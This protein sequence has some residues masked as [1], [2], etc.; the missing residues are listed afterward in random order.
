M[1][2]WLV[3]RRSHDR[4]DRAVGA[5]GTGWT[6]GARADVSLSNPTRTGALA[7][8]LVAHPGLDRGPGRRGPGARSPPDR[9]VARR[10]PAAR[11]AR[12]GLRAKRWAPPALDS[13]Q[14]AALNAAVQD[15]PHAAGLELANWNWKVV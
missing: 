3:A 14:Q 8:D 10:L 4:D 2:D 5:L 13:T 6:R 9:R 7:R 12:P 15:S 11:A 1:G